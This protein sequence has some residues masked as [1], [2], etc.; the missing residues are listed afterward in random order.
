MVVVHHKKTPYIDFKSF[1]GH[2][3]SEG[4]FGVFKSLKKRP[5]FFEGFLSLVSKMAQKNIK[6]LTYIK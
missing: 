2:L 3:V 1:K 6:V 4:N 5:K